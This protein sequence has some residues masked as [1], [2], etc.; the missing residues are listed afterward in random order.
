[1]NVEIQKLAYAQFNELQQG[2][3]LQIWTDEWLSWVNDPFYHLS[4]LAQSESPSNYPK[5]KNDRVDELI[6]AVHVVGRCRRTRSSE[7]G[8]PGDPDRRVAVCLRG[9]A[10]LDHLFRQ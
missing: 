7:Q 6:A 2:S 3:K 4:W 5:F 1:M 9:S 8:D 10:E